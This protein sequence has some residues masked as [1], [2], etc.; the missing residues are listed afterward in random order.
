MKKTLPR[1]VLTW[2]AALSL[3]LPARAAGGGYSDVQPESWYF[4]DVTEMSASGALNGYPDGTFRPDRPITGAEFVAVTARCAALAPST[5]RSGHGAAGLAQAALERGWYDWDELPPTGE[6]FDR[7][8]QRQVA[9]KIVMR[10]L[11]PQARGEYAAE[12]VKMRDFS[13]LDGRYYDAV[14]AAYASGVVTG[15]GSGAFHPGD[16]LSRAEACAIIRRALRL[17]GGDAAARPSR[18]QQP[19]QPESPAPAV[20]GGV[21]ENGRLQVVGKQ[22]CN[23]R[24]EPVVLRGMS[25]HG[26][27]WYGQY[28]SPGAVR[29]TAEYGA[30]VFRA[31][32]YTAEGGY[33]SDPEGM[34]RKLTAAVDA[35][36]E[37]DLYAIID[38]HILSDGDPMAHLREA[39]DFFTDMAARYKDS[40]AVLYEICN[41]PNGNVSWEGN[42]KPYA[43]EVVAAIRAQDPN[44]VILIGSGTWSQDIHTAAADP[45][46]GTNLMYTCH[47]YAGTHGAWLRERVRAAQDAGLPVFVSEWGTSAAD[48]SGGVFLEESRAWLDFLDER[49]ISWCC[50]SLCDKGETSAALRPG[51]S[52]DGGWTQDDLSPSGQ[53]VFSRFRA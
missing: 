8:I 25:T 47:F 18:P 17:S 28:A 34:K 38:W 15:D 51:A 1:L 12:S 22:L 21:S 11:L 31:A 43:Q 50:W 32:M 48:G 53:F 45:V 9:V 42:I 16:S 33:L 5:G 20:R 37:N 7:P 14:F 30:N 4:H 13:S 49:G 46:E 3:L 24:G 10:A 2:L 26:L 41:E 36:T 23:E 29:T 19:A 6:T 27:Q 40:P 44:G 35:A 39:K 52:P